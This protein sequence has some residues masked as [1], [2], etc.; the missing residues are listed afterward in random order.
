[1]AT[2]YVTL[3]DSNGDTIYPQISTGSLVD[4]S[5]TASKMNMQSMWGGLSGGYTGGTAG[6]YAKIMRLDFSANWKNVTIRFTFG[7]SQSDSFAYDVM[8]RV[9]R[10]SGAVRSVNLVA[11]TLQT[12]AHDLASRLK[13]V[14]LSA[15]QYELYWQTDSTGSAMANVYSFLTFDHSYDAYGKLTLYTDSTSSALPSGTTY[16]CTVKNNLIS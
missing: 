5:V 2:R 4:G 14:A 8:L 12:T 9:A 11:W 13:V 16:T 6:L 10:G 7:S 15:D 1:M 3:K